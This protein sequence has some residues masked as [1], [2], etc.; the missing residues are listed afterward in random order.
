MSVALKDLKGKWAVRTESIL[1]AH[2]YLP[3]NISFMDEPHFIIDIVRAKGY[4]VTIALEDVTTLC[5]PTIDSQPL[6]WAST[7][8][9]Y[10]TPHWRETSKAEMDKA[11]EKKS[12]EW[13]F[14]GPG[15]RDR[16]KNAI[17][18]YKKDGSCNMILLPNK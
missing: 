16:L 4:F 2:M 10:D 14:L 5:G 3:D 15:V 6:A 1:T 8:H 11:I 18:L 13:S 12:K 9:L 17:A 7:L